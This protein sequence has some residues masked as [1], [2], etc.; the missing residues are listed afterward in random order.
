ME[1]KTIGSLI[2]VLRKAAGMT[3]RELAEK[4]NVSDKSVSR[5]ERDECAPDLSLI[6]VIAEIFDIT[7]DELLRGERKHTSEIPSLEKE[8]SPY[9][10]EKSTK[11]F[12]HLLRMQMLKFKERSLLT[13]GVTIGGY[14]TALICNFVFLKSLLGFFLALPFYTA[15]VILEI[16]FL[17]RSVMA[18]EDAFD[19][20]QW[21]I[22][23]NDIMKIGIRSFAWILFFF[24]AVLP[25]LLLGDS[26]Y[27]LQFGSYFILAFLSLTV[28][29]LA[30]GI[31]YFLIIQPSLAK[32]G[33]LFLTEE[34]K[35]I[36]Y[37]K[38][39]LLIKT[40]IISACI[41]FILIIAAAVLTESASLFTER[42]RFDDYESFREYMETPAPG[43][44]FE[45]ETEI[46]EPLT[47]C[48]AS[49]DILCEYHWNNRDVIEIDCSFE[50]KE[51]GLPIYVITASAR[52]TAS[53][54]AQDLAGICVSLAVLQVVIALGIY[55]F[56]SRKIKS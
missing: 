19:R 4:L 11:Q 40:V 45:G 2:A 29:S 42:I 48:N 31:F 18:E 46:L 37:K 22:Y 52:L 8:E 43:F 16:C 38:R 9:L 3:Q 15:A 33:Y 10:K 54:I 6:P 56:T 1:K 23:Q 28:F 51:T 13:F 47:I 50:N 39:R 12:Q 53:Y 25:L 21:H 41:A 14:I 36:A 26:H 55:L 5:W 17:R 24:A 44:E 27:G 49:G 34:E 32:N 7:T 20:S 30:G 35:A